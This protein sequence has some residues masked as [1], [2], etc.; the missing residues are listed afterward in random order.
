MRAGTPA[1]RKQEPG[2][3]N[4]LHAAL[5]KASPPYNQCAFT[6]LP[7]GYELEM[8]GT[9]CTATTHA[10][11]QELVTQPS[12]AGPPLRSGGENGPLHLNS[13]ILPPN[14]PPAPS[15]AQPT[16]PHLPVQQLGT[17]VPPVVR[18]IASTEFA[19]QALQQ[20]VT[21]LP[22]LQVGKDAEIALLALCWCVCEWVVCGKNNGFHILLLTSV[23]SC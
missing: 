22:E 11:T 1:A 15:P 21:R 4:P 19:H 16:L 3:C 12:S 13:S 23:T 8:Q 2:P 10:A 20:R 18:L 7:L 14:P 17:S 9:Y 6:F 5:G